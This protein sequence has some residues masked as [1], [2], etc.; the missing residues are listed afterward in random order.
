MIFSLR[1]IPLQDHSG[2]VCFSIN[3]HIQLVVNCNQGISTIIVKAV[4]YLSRVVIL[5]S[6]FSLIPIVWIAIASQSNLSRQTI[7]WIVFIVCL[8][9][10]L[11]CSWNTQDLQKSEIESK[12]PLSMIT[13]EVTFTEPY[14]L[15]VSSV[16]SSYSKYPSWYTHLSNIT[17]SCHYFVA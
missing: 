1:H 12:K 17:L 14:V 3:Y 15:I 8:C 10:P 9:L 4:F 16:I 2:L 7:L 13:Q 5:S 11:P 6:M